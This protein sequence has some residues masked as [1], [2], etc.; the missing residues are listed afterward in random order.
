MRDLFLR[1]VSCQNDGENEK[2]LGVLM[3]RS[4]MVEIPRL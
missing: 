3:S 2:I 4:G 1:P